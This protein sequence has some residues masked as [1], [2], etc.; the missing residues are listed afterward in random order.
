MPLTSSMATD[1]CKHDYN[2]MNKCFKK[3][4]CCLVGASALFTHAHLIDKMAGYYFF[5]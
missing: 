3:G 1:Y 5:L 4:S 2:A